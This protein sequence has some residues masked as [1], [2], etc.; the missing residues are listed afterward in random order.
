MDAPSRV[1]NPTRM[2]ELCVR[3]CAMNFTF[4]FQALASTPL[5]GVVGVNTE[6]WND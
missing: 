1:T 2:C 5:D 4:Q 6:M 3:E